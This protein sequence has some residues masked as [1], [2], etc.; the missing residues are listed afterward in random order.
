MDQHTRVPDVVT[1]V[2]KTFPLGKK[3]HNL[4][5]CVVSVILLFHHLRI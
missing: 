5:G 3:K 1:T 2:K 4:S